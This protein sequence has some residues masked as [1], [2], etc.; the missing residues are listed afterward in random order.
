MT[1]SP[2]VTLV[3]FTAFV[4]VMAMF[5]ASLF[6]VFGQY[7]TGSTTEYSAVFTDVSRLS[8]G[9]TVRVAGIRVGTVRDVSLRDDNTVVVSF[10]ADRSIVVSDGT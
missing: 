6:F 1:G 2:Y 7:R 3:K 8:A 9:Q 4:A 5:T 10:D